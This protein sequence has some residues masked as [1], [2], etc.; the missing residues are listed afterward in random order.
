MNRRRF[1]AASIGSAASVALSQPPPSNPKPAR[2]PQGP[3][4]PPGSTIDD[5]EWQD[6]V[7]KAQRLLHRYDMAAMLVPG[8]SSLYYFT[9]RREGL[10][11]IVAGRSPIFL[12]ETRDPYRVL[13]LLLRGKPSRGRIGL[14]EGAPF[15]MVEALRSALPHAKFV[16]ATPVTAGCRSIKSKTEI[17]LLRRANTFTMRAYKAVIPKLRA[18][19]TNADVSAMVEAEYKTMGVAG[20]AMVIFGKYTPNPHGSNET[21]VLRE[22]DVVLIDDGCEVE[23]YQSDVTRTF[24]FGE[25]TARHRQVWAVERAAQDAV[26]RAAKPGATHESVDAAARAVIEKAGYGPGYKLPGLPHRTGHGIGLDGHEWTYLVRG[27]RARIE[28]GMVFS[29]EP[30]IVIPGEFGIRLE[31]CMYIADDGAHF[32]TPQAKSI[33]EPFG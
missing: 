24:V 28:V 15:A 33:E 11:L 16:S 6:R 14:E 30:T 12:A 21:Q 10:W 17:E 29:N 7:E 32:F 18:G 9:G 1:V 31:D 19:M 26:L 22:G 23:G 25:P 8:G 4:P 3:V 27:N 5:D 20:D 13:G 2:V